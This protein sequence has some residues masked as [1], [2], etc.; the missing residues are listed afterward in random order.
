MAIPG[1]GPG[2]TDCRRP[3][4]AGGGTDRSARAGGARGWE[5]AGGIVR[6]SAARAT[7]GR[8]AVRAVAFSAG[9]TG[10]PGG[11]FVGCLPVDFMR[12]FDAAAPPG[13]GGTARAVKP[14]RAGRGIGWEVGASRVRYHQEAA[15]VN[16]GGAKTPQ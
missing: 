14:V 15:G 4:G 2:L 1:G 12:V 3:G 13:E 8:A 5:G 7:T 9:A 11:G 16:V 10:A 6:G